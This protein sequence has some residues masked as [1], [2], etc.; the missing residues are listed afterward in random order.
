MGRNTWNMEKWNGATF[1]SETAMYRPNENISIDRTS[2][3]VKTRLADGS[4]GFFI[5]ETKYIKEPITMQFL[6]IASSDSFR[7]RLENYVQNND[8][9]RITDHLG[10]TYTGSFVSVK[11]VW[12]TGISPD[13]VD[14]EAVFE[15]MA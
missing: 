12:L 1:V 2:T 14:L 8:Y 11:R 4:N 6:G 15:V 7:T 5:P 13:E 9:L 3:Q 10:S